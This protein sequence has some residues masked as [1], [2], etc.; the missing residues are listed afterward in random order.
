MLA[1]LES[2][3][4][5]RR[6]RPRRREIEDHVETGIGD[7]LVDRRGGKVVLGAERVGDRLV[8]VGTRDDVEDIQ[9]LAG[10][11]VHGADGAAADH[12]DFGGRHAHDASLPT[13]ARAKA[14]G[15]YGLTFLMV[16]L[17]V[18]SE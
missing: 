16:V 15:V 7:Q 3:A 8:Q 5:D 10:F 12:A 13:I 9:G 2:C 14:P 4:G 11:E 6:V 18:L 1:V 17:H